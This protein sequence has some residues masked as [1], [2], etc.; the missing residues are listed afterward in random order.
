MPN[1]F[2]LD[3][4]KIDYENIT[5]ICYGCG[6]QDHKFDTCYINVECVFKVETIGPNQ[7]TNF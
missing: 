5:E 3:L 7:E 4:F 1:G 6:S 2:I